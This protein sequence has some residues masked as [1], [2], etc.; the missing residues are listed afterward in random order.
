MF[1]GEQAMDLVL[2]HIN[3]IGNVANFESN[4]HGKYDGLRWGIEAR[5][6]GGSRNVCD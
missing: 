6:E 1:A 3:G 4:A 5:E 2:E